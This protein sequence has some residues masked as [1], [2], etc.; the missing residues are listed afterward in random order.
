A[1]Y[2]LGAGFDYHALIDDGLGRTASL[3]AGAD[4]APQHVWTVSSSA[5]VALG[6]AAFGRTRAPD[7][8][9]ARAGWGKGD[10]ELG[11]SAGREQA[12]IG[13]SAFDVAPDGSVVVLDQVNQRLA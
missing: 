10:R 6:P 11:L 7:A 3:P 2:T 9:V 5:V 13:P 4:D 12:R 1:R 8:I